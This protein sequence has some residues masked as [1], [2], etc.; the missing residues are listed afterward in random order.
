MKEE[1][2]VHGTSNE[3]DVLGVIDPNVARKDQYKKIFES[4]K[5][6]VGEPPLFSWIEFNLVGLCNRRCDFCPWSDPE[7]RSN[8]VPKSSGN[9]DVLHLPVESFMKEFMKR[10]EQSG[11]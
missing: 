1:L 9:D 4:K 3:S 2:F 6:D 10:F 11:I 8:H 5:S 7:W